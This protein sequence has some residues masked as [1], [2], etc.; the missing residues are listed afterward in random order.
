MADGWAVPP[1]ISGDWRNLIVAESI[2]LLLRYAQNAESDRLRR[3]FVENWP[4]RVRAM[5]PR[6]YPGWILAEVQAVLPDGVAGLLAFLYGPGGIVTIDG[7]SNPIHE[8]N[9]TG[10]LDIKG[11]PQALDYL[12]FFCSAIHGDE[13]RFQIVESASDLLPVDDAAARAAVLEAAKSL[14]HASV[15]GDEGAYTGHGSVLYGGSLFNASFSIESTGGITMIDD[16]P[17]TRLPVRREL[18]RPPF[19]IVEAEPYDA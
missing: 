7:S 16:D 14:S 17:L 12:R 15:H 8:L 6:F 2:P 5:R 4:V 1:L 3:L 10:A 13:G 19:R 11:L 18:F 9:G